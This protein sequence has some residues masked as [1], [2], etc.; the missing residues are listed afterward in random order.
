MAT[1]KKNTSLVFKSKPTSEDEYQKLA[2]DLVAWSHNNDA[3]T[4]NSFPLSIM[5]SPALFHDLPASS[6]YFAQ[7]Y[8]IALQTVGSRRERLAR[9]GIID[10]QIVLE[11]MPLYDPAYRKWR[12]SQ[13]QKTENSSGET[14]FIVVE[15]P[16]LVDK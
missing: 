5:M 1:H 13:R 10:K 3:L 6:E 7:A 4:I 2:D 8:D 11:T 14:K 15:M 12:L 16:K 9:E